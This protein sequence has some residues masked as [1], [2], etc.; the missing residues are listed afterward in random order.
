MRHLSLILLLAACPK[1]DAAPPDAPSPTPTTVT[2]DGAYHAVRCG[3]VTAVWSGSADDVPAEG[4]KSYGV[5]GLSFRLS[6]GTSVPFTPKGELSFSDWSFDLFS[7]DCATVALLEDR[8]GP[9]RLVA[10]SALKT[11][12]GATVEAP[13]T[14]ETASVHGQWRWTSAT[15]FEFVASCCGGARVFGGETAAPEKLSQR[16][17]AVSAPRGVV[18]TKGGWEVVK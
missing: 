10:T 16:F 18:P 15:T 2:L 1:K 17:E 3:A 14:G 8:F 5:T 11:M 13:K 4:P 12:A 6:D 7:P 9:Y